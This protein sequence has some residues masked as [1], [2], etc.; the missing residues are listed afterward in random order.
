MANQKTTKTA[1]REKIQRVVALAKRH[2]TAAKCEF[3]RA[4]LTYNPKH[5]SYSLWV[6]GTVFDESGGWGETNTQA[7]AVRLVKRAVDMVA[8]GYSNT[9]EDEREFKAQA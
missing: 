4:W 3:G 6:N 7:D 2:N 8:A 9:P 5:N 1:I